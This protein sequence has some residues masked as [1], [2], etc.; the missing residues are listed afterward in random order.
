MSPAV[1][2]V[3]TSLRRTLVQYTIAQL[4]SKRINFS[5]IFAI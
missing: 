2:L 3:A 5:F 4:L 1:V